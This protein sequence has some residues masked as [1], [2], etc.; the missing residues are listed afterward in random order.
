MRR[1]VL[2]VIVVLAVVAGSAYLLSGRPDSSASAPAADSG[3][4][5]G[6]GGSPGG[7]GVIRPP[8][9]V[10]LTKAGRAD[11]NDRILIVG[12][13][14]GAATVDVVPK[15][16]GRLQSI[17]VRIG[18]RVSRGETIAEVEAHEIQE[19]VKQAQASYEVGAASVRQRE[20][21][22]KF[23]ETSL[24]RSRS[25]F[26]RQLVSKQTL[27]D[28]EARQ[29]AAAA[30]LDL[31]RAQ[32][33][34]AKARL[35]ELQFSL[36]NTVIASPVD[37]FVG[38]RNLDPGA[39]VS[40]NAPVVSVVDIRLVRLVANLVEKDLRRVTPGMDAEVEVDAYPGETFKGRVT[41]VAPVL[42]PATRTAQ[43]EVE[44]PNTGFRLK[45][46]MYARVRITVDQRAAALVVPRNAVV[47]VQ[48]TRGV[49]IATDAPAGSSSAAGGGRPGGGPRMTAAFRPVETGLQER[50]L[51]EI[52]KGL[53]EGDR[54]VTTGATSLR[55][56]D[57]ILLAGAAR[58]NRGAPGAEGGRP[59]GGAD[60]PRR[61]STL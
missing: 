6:P 51:V 39:W 37:G 49:F 31:A 25:L 38:K 54:I 21:D 33:N 2:I 44:V 57:R 29:Q 10:E 47:D 19:Q 34:Q 22:L 9:T 45:P 41:R 46:G 5:N 1:I 58:G 28:S 59:G 8:M 13:L 23:A 40:P 48:G 16:S 55:D 42:D 20:A 30:Q 4:G 18:D 15:I 35:D 52:I 43:M 53:S 36:A 14:I 50:D 27:D 11:L 60:Q 7:G 24:E 32:L 3:R 17:G 12:N 61:Q 56:G 26:N